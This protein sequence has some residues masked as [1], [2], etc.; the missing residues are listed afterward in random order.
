MNEMIEGCDAQEWRTAY[1][2][3]ARWPRDLP[4]WRACRCRHDPSRLSWRG[5]LDRTDV[6]FSKRSRKSR[7][8]DVRNRDGYAG[9]SNL[10]TSHEL[11]RTCDPPQGSR[12]VDR[13]A[14]GFHGTGSRSRRVLHLGDVYG[15]RGFRSL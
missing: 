3:L 9:Q 10:A 7:I 5:R 8:D 14:C 4:R 6:R 2:E 11:R 12:G 15:W 13:T 1:C